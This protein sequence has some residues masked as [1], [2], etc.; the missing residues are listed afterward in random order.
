LAGRLVRCCICFYA[1]L[2]SRSWRDWSRMSEDFQPNSHSQSTYSNLKDFS[3][4]T[5]NI[6]TSHQIAIPNCTFS[7]ST[8]PIT[9]KLAIFHHPPPFPIPF[10]TLLNTTWDQV[11]PKTCPLFLPISGYK[12]SFRDYLLLTGRVV[13][14]PCGVGFLFACVCCRCITHT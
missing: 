5:Q 13:V 9:V 1:R 11:F 4:S 3:S 2:L 7:H 14:A 12:W 6:P 8:V 10:L